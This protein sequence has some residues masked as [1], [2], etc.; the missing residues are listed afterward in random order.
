VSDPKRPS[1][2]LVIGS[3]GQDGR[4]ISQILLKNGYEVMGVVRKD[5]KPVYSQNEFTEIESDLSNATCF[6]TLLRE[7]EPDHIFHFGAVHANSRDMRDLE[8]SQSDEMLKCHAKIT[9]NILEW[10]TL[11]SC[12]SLI[13]LSS[14]IY[15]PQF[16]NHEISLE[17]PF[18]PQ[19]HY[20]RTKLQA[21][22]HIRDYRRK[23]GV[24][25]AGLILFNHASEFS[26]SEFLIPSIASNLFNT[27][28]S[29][30]KTLI[31]NSQQLVDISN[32]H[33]FCSGFY[34]IIEKEQY[35]DFIFSSGNLRSIQSLYVDAI[36]RLN[37][38]LISLFEFDNLGAQLPSMFGNIERTCS[39]LDWKGGGDSIAI[40]EKI[41]KAK[42]DEGV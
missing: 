38:S 30:K 18:N 36:N 35:G 42:I 24:K 7:I 5:S 13:A 6:S 2:A 17:E 1:R 27:Y 8:L 39:I 10:Q 15:T 37:P 21:L 19:N 34:K 33:E 22:K 14:F 31:K 25:S 3:R 9:Q 16:P 20:G 28:K 32:A 4:I 41:F 12:T 11:N 40:I 26:K 29:G 23:F